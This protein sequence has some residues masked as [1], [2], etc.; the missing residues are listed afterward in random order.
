MSSTRLREFDRQLKNIA[1]AT[2]STNGFVF[3]DGRVFRRTVQHEGTTSWQ[4][5]EFQVGQ[6]NFAGRFT[7]NLGVFNPD[8]LPVFRTG[9]RAEPHCVDCLSDLRQRLGF[10]RPPNR[11]FKDRI[12]HRTPVPC[13]YWW[14]QNADPK[15]M[16]D[17]MS[18]ASETLV[19]FGLTWLSSRTSLTAFRWAARQL[20]RRKAWKAALG[21]PNSQLYFD[22]E[23]FPEQSNRKT[24][25]LPDDGQSR[26]G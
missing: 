6:R 7:V 16:R 11:S 15:T 25:T 5:I 20:E 13:D 8:H 9:G 2:L 3:R 10:F 26:R 22:P 21:S 23:P 17:E 1:G 12:L 18:D 19:T 4:L 24:A 14:F